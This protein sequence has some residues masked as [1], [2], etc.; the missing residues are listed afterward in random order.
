[1]RYLSLFS[2]IEAATQAWHSL[3]WECVGV[4]EIE[5]FPCRLLQHY[6]PHVPN[7]GDV[8]KI[9]EETIANLGRIDIVVFGSPCQDLSVAGKRKGLAGARS[10]LFFAAVDIARWARDWG[11][12]DSLFGRTYP[13]HSAATKAETL[14]QWLTHWRVWNPEPPKSRK[15]RSGVWKAPPSAPT[16]WSSGA[17]STRSG[18][19]WRSGAV[20]CSLSQ[21][22]ERGPIDP[23]YFLSPKACAGILRRAEARGRV[24]PPH[25][26]A[27]LKAVAEA[28]TPAA[29]R[30]TT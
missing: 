3:G 24:L 27:A 19:E 18:S 7:L 21:I 6:Y 23:R 28:D 26:H 13:E 15:G 17:L 14:Q 22:L 5:P 9:T 2:G 1:M 8:T 16:E 29:D 25:L 30:K 10:N 20:A 4:A 12:A 11:D